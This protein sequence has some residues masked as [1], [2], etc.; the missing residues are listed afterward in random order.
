MKYVSLDLETTGLDPESNQILEFAAVFEDGA[1]QKPVYDLPFF[2]CY[3]LHAKLVGHP[4]AISMNADIIKKLA[5]H[6]M[7]E[8]W[9]ASDIEGVNYLHPVS[10]WKVFKPWMESNYGCALNA[11]GRGRIQAT[12]AGKNPSFDRSFC[13][14]LPGWETGCFYYRTADPAMFY[15]D[16]VNDVMIPD[17]AACAARAGVSIG[18]LHNAL[19]DARRVIELIRKGAKYGLL[20]SG[21]G[22]H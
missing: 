8:I 16:F 21:T 11:T 13:S 10:V 7:D 19:A 2:H 12:L 4:V 22:D 14:K 1:N 18:G 17:T 9:H 20:A 6:G 5:D 15:T 3:L